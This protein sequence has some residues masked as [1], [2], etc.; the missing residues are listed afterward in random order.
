MKQRSINHTD[1]P[2]FFSECR[3]SNDYEAA[4]AYGESN[5]CTIPC[6]GDSK[7]SCGGSSVNDVYVLGFPPSPKQ[8]DAPPL[9][10]IFMGLEP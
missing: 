2:F 6:Q 8:S 3:A 9:S 5:Q 10:Q 1:A 7:Q 4:T